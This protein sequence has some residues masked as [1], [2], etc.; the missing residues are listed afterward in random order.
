[1][2]KTKKREAEEKR[3]I[4]LEQR[5]KEAIVG[6]DGAI[7]TV[8]PRIRTKANGW[9]KDEHPLIFL[10]LGSSGTGKTELAKQVA[11]YLF[12]DNEEAFIR[13]DMSE[14]KEKHEVSIKMKQI[15]LF[16]FKLGI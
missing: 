16:I 8:A 3:P 6:Q 15:K 14:Y 4:P 7:T 9:W 10:F 13:F 11:K 2:R 1:M 12:K 5:I